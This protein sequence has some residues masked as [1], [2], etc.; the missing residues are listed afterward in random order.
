M[1]HAGQQS[2]LEQTFLLVLCS[3]EIRPDKKSLYR[4]KDALDD[5]HDEAPCTHV[6]DGVD[7]YPKDKDPQPLNATCLQEKIT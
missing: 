7:P 3:I 6:G 2:A 5:H 1:V 4:K